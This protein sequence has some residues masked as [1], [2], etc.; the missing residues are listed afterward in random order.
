MIPRP[1]TSAPI[2]TLLPEVFCGRSREPD[3]DSKITIGTI[4]QMVMETEPTV[5]DARAARGRGRRLPALRDRDDRAPWTVEVSGERRRCVGAVGAAPRL[6]QVR[7]DRRR[8]RRRARCSGPP[9]AP[10]A[11]STACCRRPRSGPSANASVSPK[12]SLRGCCVSA[13]R[14]SRAG[15]PDGTFRPSPWRCSSGSF[16]IYREASTTSAGTPHR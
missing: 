1:G 7:R 5:D 9:S 8:S 6:P 10:T 3:L 13:G 2:P 15:N 4:H 16:A 11:R 14:Q 12:A